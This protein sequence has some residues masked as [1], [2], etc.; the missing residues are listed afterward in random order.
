MWFKCIDLF[1]A[2]EV[3]VEMV[4]GIGLMDFEL[5]HRGFVADTDFE[6]H[7]KEGLLEKE[8]SDLITLNLNCKSRRE[9]SVGRCEDCLN[10]IVLENELESE[11]VVMTRIKLE[12]FYSDKMCF[13]KSSK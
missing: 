5:D 8:E 13:V 2:R 3:V 1:A 6:W 4:I 7:F 11:E 9:K 10:R 12:Q